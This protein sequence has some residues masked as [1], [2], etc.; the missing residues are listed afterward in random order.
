[1][2]PHFASLWGEELSTESPLIKTKYFKNYYR[3][4]R[5]ADESLIFNS[6]TQKYKKNYQ[7]FGFS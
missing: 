6:G 7:S 4:L 1:M 3:H 2:K 5:G